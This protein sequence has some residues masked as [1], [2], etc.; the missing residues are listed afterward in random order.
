MAGKYFLERTQKATI[1]DREIYKLDFIKIKNILSK[2]VIKKM[3]KQPQ[4]G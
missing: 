3:N 4:L 1:K 2:E